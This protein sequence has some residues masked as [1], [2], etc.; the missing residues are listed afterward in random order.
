MPLGKVHSIL[1]TTCRIPVTT[2]YAYDERR[3]GYTTRTRRPEDQKLMHVSCTQAEGNKDCASGVHFD[4]FI[5]L[6][7]KAAGRLQAGSEGSTRGV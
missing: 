7:F 4:K 2:M 6:R 1:C 5:Q 3:C